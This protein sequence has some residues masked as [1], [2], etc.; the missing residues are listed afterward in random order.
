MENNE[1]FDNIRTDIKKSVAI[2]VVDS[3]LEVKASLIEVL[4]AENLK[5]RQKVEKLEY[6]ISELESVQQKEQH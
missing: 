1:Q 4:K 3:L 2:T 6:S 5:L